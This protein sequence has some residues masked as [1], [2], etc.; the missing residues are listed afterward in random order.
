LRGAAGSRRAKYRRSFGSTKRIHAAQ[1]KR[2][3]T[4]TLEEQ[5]EKFLNIRLAE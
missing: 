1:R 3:W 2:Y 5:E 4:L